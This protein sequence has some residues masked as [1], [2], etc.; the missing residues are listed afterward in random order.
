M[1]CECKCKCLYYALYI[2][3]D[4][5]SSYLNCTCII[6]LLYCLYLQHVGEIARGFLVVTYV[7]FVD[8]CS[9]N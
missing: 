5:D 2:T 8:Y 9:V 1:F 7:L 3:E 6:L 4:Y